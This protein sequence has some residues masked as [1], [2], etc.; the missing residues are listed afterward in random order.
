MRT[1][2]VFLIFIDGDL[3]KTPEHLGVGFLATVLR[4]HG[5]SCAIV[6]IAPGKELAAIEKIKALSPRFLGLSLTTV[7][8]PRAQRVGQ[9]LRKVL[10]PDTHFCAGGPIVTF[11]GDRLLRSGNWPFLDSLVRGEGEEVIVP[12][13][14]RVLA[15]ERCH[16]LCGVTV[17]GHPPA[18]PMVVAVDDLDRLPW[19]ARDQIEAAHAERRRWPYLRLSTSRGCTSRCAFCNAPNAGNNLA[20]RKGWRG[21]RPE[22]V[23]D[24][25][26]ELVK[27]FNADTFDFVDSTFEDPGG[28]KRGKDR[29]RRIAEL[30]IER[31]LQIFYNICCQACNWHEEDRELLSLL[32]RSGL[33]K[34]L[35]GI[36]SGSERVL[37]RFNKRST[38][39][40]NHRALRLFREQGV[41]VAF[42]FIMFQPYGEWQD[43]EDNVDF[44]LAQ[45]GHNLRRFVI[46]LE[47]Y[48]GAEIVH[49]LEADG[50]LHDDY[51]ETLNP[52]AYDYVDPQIGRMAE[53]INRLFGQD[54]LRGGMIDKEPSVFAFEIYDITLHTYMSRLRRLHRDEPVIASM[55][56]DTTELIERE[57]RKLTQFNAD[58]FARYLKMARSGRGS[59]DG[60]PERVEEHYARAMDEL[61][62]IQMRLGMNL[63]RQGIPLPI[64][65]SVA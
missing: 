64:S 34:V 31:N 32:Y 61:K 11:L 33:E 17:P 15:G 20:K 65:R 3:V 19:P 44:L 58:L 26:E 2:C 56:D 5:Y 24:E 12:L 48:P 8:L 47:L 50:L 55:L 22:R 40:D 60:E 53:M 18:L 1:T 7:N 9:T 25:I 16:D 54:Y 62:S 10:R 39:E 29:I 63:R 30:I 51:W 14:K 4:A 23:V 21:C 45:L 13:V 57:F 27:R 37:K 42:G 59:T 43:L 46:R 52:Y 35:I 49:R 38:V 41:Y 6:E 36:E 28:R